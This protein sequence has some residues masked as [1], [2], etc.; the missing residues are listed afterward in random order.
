MG[1][2]L[3]LN[4]D[5]RQNDMDRSDYIPSK[6][7]DYIGCQ[8]RCDKKQDCFGFTYNQ[9]NQKCFLKAAGE[10]H[11]NSYVGAVSAIKSCY[12]RDGE[13]KGT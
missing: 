3:E 6:V 1:G 7:S 9:K 2:C 5:F 4:I 12:Q 13:T 10:V 11:R 8:K